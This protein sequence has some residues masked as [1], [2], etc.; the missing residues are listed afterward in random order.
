MKTTTIEVADDILGLLAQSK[1]G[2]W[3]PAEQIQTALA[4][5][6]FQE[7]VIS[8]GKAA[9]LAGELRPSFERLLVDIGIPP[10]RY[11]EQMY[12]EDLEGLAHAR[13]IGS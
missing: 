9:E 13:H 11:D 10:V 12:A 4:I 3:P 6:L 1:L 2:S 8:V 7:G 5:H